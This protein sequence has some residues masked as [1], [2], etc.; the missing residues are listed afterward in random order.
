MR[1]FDLDNWGEC[2]CCGKDNIPTCD[3]LCERCWNEK[4]NQEDDIKKDRGLYE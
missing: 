4:I 1:Y 2:F 3:G